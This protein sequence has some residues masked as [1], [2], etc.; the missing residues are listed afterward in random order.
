MA[1][2]WEDQGKEEVTGDLQPPE[3]ALLWGRGALLWGRGALPCG[4]GGR[5]GHFLRLLG[6]KQVG[7]GLRQSGAPQTIMSS[8]LEC[9][10]LLLHRLAKLTL[11]M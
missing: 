5:E 7:W 10:K 6:R 3:C 9:V 2:K 8:S 1:F 4:R 11:Q